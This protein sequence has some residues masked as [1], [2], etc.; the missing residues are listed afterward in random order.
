V[1]AH[2]D[3]GHPHA[4]ALA[5]YQAAARTVLRT[6]R[7]GDVIVTVDATGCY[8]VRTAHAGPAPVARGGPATCAAPSAKESLP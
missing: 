6:D 7:D 4:E 2:N 5:A 8:E 3:Y 1:A